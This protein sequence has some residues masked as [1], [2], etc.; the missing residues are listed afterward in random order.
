MNVF[1]ITRWSTYKI[2]L[3]SSSSFVFKCSFIWIVIVYANNFSLYYRFIV[4]FIF[5]DLDPS[6]YMKSKFCL[7]YE[8][9][10]TWTL[11]VK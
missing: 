2:D 5:I 4:S 7:K 1:Q 9:R 8:I 6:I 10:I 3:F 11:I